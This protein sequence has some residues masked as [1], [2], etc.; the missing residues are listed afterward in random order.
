[1]FLLLVACAIPVP[2]KDCV[3]ATDTA[4]ATADTAPC[5]PADIAAFDTDCDLPEDCAAV[6]LDSCLPVSGGHVALDRVAL[7]AW[8]A[9]EHCDCLSG[10]T[11][12]TIEVTA[13]CTD[14]LCVVVE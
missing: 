13:T 10:T 3:E 6:P 12:G 2:C 11:S 4:T 7:D 1:V 8:N 9:A 14:G 5:V